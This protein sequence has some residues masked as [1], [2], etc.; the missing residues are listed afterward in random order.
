MITLFDTPID[1]PIIITLTVIFF[2]TSSITTFDKRLIQA[3][4][5]GNI[6]P[7]EEMLPSWVGVIAWFHWAVGLSIML[8]NWQFALIVFVSKFILSVLPVLETIGN[9][10]MAPFRTRK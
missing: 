3:V 7:D 4:K 1:S 9:V 2:I 10:L 5:N 8:L 6:P